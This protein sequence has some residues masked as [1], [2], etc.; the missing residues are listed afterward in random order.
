MMP[1]H[2]WRATSPLRLLVLGFL[3]LCCCASL[4]LRCSASYA[5]FLKLDATSPEFDVDLGQSAEARWTRLQRFASTPL[6]GWNSYDGWDWS[7][8]ERDV[9]GNMDYLAANLSS[10][11]YV[12]ATIDYYWYMDLDA[13]TLYLDQYGRLQPDPNRF[14]SSNGNAGYKKLAAYAH[15]KGL[16]FGIHTMRGISAA[17]VMQKLPVLGTNY[18]ADEVYDATAACP[19]HAGGEAANFYSLNMSHPGGQLFYNALFAQY[20]DWGVDFVKN[21]C[22]FAQYVPEQVYAVS[23]A[24]EASGRQMLYS[25][26]PGDENR[27]WAAGIASQVNMYRVTGDTWDRW[28]NIASHWE[29]AQQMQPFI[30]RPG[31]RYGLPSWPDLDVSLDTGQCPPCSARSTQ[32]PPPHARC[33][34]LLLPLLRCCPSAGWARKA[35]TRRPTGCAR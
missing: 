14:P 34:L 30:A 23:A 29:S 18:T 17:A 24:M 2:V 8:T 22:V 32:P 9:V 6:K 33:L 27:D 19:W 15:S 25:L 35:P 20:A 7:V 12:I 10:L 1:P 21:D 3:C 4:P 28:D 31:G 16:L 11:G 26:S 13:Q 5:D